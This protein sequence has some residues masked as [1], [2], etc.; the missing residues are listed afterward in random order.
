MNE[1]NYFLLLGLK[2]SAGKNEIE[3]RINAKAEEWTRA[4][5]S[6][7][8]MKGNDAVSNL[9][10]L[11]DMKRVLLYWEEDLGASDEHSRQ[12]KEAEEFICRIEDTIKGE[13]CFYPSLEDWKVNELLTKYGRYG[14]DESDIRD[15]FDQARVDA[16]GSPG[17]TF[18]KDD[19]LDKKQ[20]DKIR[21][22]LTRMDPSWE[23]RTLYEF[24][25]MSPRAS[26]GEL[27]Q[28]AQRKMAEAAANGQQSS[29]GGK[30]KDLYQICMEQFAS[31]KSKKQ[32]DN[33]LDL[34]KD[35][36]R[37][38]NNFVDT[39]VKNEGHFSRERAEAFLITVMKSP[40]MSISA[41]EAVDHIIDYCAYNGYELD[42]INR[43]ELISRYSAFQSPTPPPPVDTRKNNDLKDLKRTLAY[44]EKAS[45]EIQKKIAEANAQ[46]QAAGESRAKADKEQALAG[47]TENGLGQESTEHRNH[48]IAA[49][50]VCG[51]GWVGGLTFVERSSSNLLMALFIIIVII[52]PIVAVVQLVRM[53]SSRKEENTMAGNWKSEAEELNK[54]AEYE[55]EQAEQLRLQ[56]SSLLK[57]HD[58]SLILPGEYHLDP[59][60][61]EK[62]RKY[63]D[64]GIAEDLDEIVSALR[65]G[66]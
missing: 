11:E 49:A 5:N 58:D 20:A 21:K 43:E 64:E 24:L 36:Y 42:S 13:L 15:L 33:Y 62:A 16:G 52:T 31:D 51:F 61:Y 60:A 23:N 1:K 59:Q 66:I 22:Y 35:C 18:N 29:S 26:A 65:C 4:K 44:G 12:K 34:V 40:D 2:P 54:T 8:S 9:Q 55:Y 19:Y 53:W 28:E 32:Y 46:E 48:A 30:I 27:R 6:G 38:P 17:R 45:G 37:G 57:K 10:N 41:G 56:V 50:V 14:F 47:Q 3:Q 7:R 63:V 25:E 39:V